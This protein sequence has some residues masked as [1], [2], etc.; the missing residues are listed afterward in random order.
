[1]DSSLIQMAVIATLALAPTV[2]LMLARKKLGLLNAAAWLVIY[3]SAIIAG[4]HTFIGLALLR[5]L[6]P[7]LDQH[8]R[9]HFFMG[10]VYTSVAAILLGVVAWTLR[11]N[12]SRGEWYAILFGLV[13]GGG[14]ELLAASTVFPHGF[15]P[16]SIPLGLFVYAYIPALAAA[17]AISYRPVFRTEAAL[18]H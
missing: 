4:E 8:A 2:G 3:G 6:G 18:L 17:L 13:L 7:A 5:E 10:G 16:K 11:R 14:F 1:M 15:P 9:F 12:G